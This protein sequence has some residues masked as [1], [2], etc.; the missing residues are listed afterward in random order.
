MSYFTVLSQAEEDDLHAKR[1]LNI[2]EKPYKRIQKRLLAPSN[3]IHEYLR[4]KSVSTSSDENTTSDLEADTN[5]TASSKTEEEVEAYLTSLTQFQHSTLHDF[6]AL[7]TSLARLQFLFS[8]N[9]AERERYTNQ[10]TTIT[11][12]QTSIREQTTAL[13]SRLEEAREQLQIR[14]GYDVL[15]EKVLK[16]E[17]TGETAKTR[18]ELGVACDKLRNEIEELEREGEEIKGAWRERREVL[19]DVIGE[20]GRLRRVIRGEPEHIV[21]DRE[22][23]D[24]GSET[25]TNVGEDGE[26]DQQRRE[27]EDDGLLHVAEGEGAPSASNAGTPRPMDIDAPTPLPNLQGSGGQTPGSVVAD[28]EVTVDPAP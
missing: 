17:K 19:K 22:H 28:I 20:A 9:V 23:D 3:P 1:L 16:D 6:S 24:E 2:E 26:G 7:T 21:E 10:V 27:E 4:R 25:G 13:R 5:G 15:A 18:E 12:Q 8:A 14:K 11:S